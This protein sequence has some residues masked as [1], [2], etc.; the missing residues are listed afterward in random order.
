MMLSDLYIK[1]GTT[2]NTF[3]G[4]ESDDNKGGS[5]Y[6]YNVEIPNLSSKGG[7]LEALRG[8]ER[9]VNGKKELEADYRLSCD[10]LDILET[11]VIFI[12]STGMSLTAVE[13]DIVFVQPYDFGNNPHL[14]IYIKRIE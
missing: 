1:Q 8:S 9:I 2:F 11:D 7:W 10:V 6:I 5:Q 12:T 13:F 14:E 3:R 4:T